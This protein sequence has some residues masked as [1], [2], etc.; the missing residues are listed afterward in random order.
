MNYM[1]K[2]VLF[3]IINILP[4][5]I[6]G[7]Y[8][9]TNIGG[10]EDV[11]EVV[12]NSPFKEFIYIDYKTLMILKDNADI[13]NI[14]A[15]YKETLIFIN[16]IY[17]GN[18]GSIGI[19]VPLGFLIKYIPIGN[20]EYYNGVL[21]KNPN[22]FDLGKAE[23][24]DLINTVPSNYKDVLIY[25]KDYVI[26][27]YYDLNSNKTYLVYV[28]KKSDNREIDTEKLKNELLQKTDAVDCNVIDMGN[29]IYV[30]QEFN[31]INLNLISNGIL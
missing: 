5:A 1:K 9:C 14:P 10:A 11:K 24:N 21:I 23:I 16:G 20:F 22:E 7:L 29:E 18:H 3:L 30:Y 25:K 31:G 8:L 2:I 28:F 4:I 6:L 13:Q 17:I 12:E 27:I 19:K 15:I 26:G